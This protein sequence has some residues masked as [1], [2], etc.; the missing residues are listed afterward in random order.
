MCSTKNSA[1]FAIH[2]KPF[3]AKLYVVS[4]TVIS[5]NFFHSSVIQY[6]GSSFWLVFAKLSLLDFLFMISAD[7][8]ECLTVAVPQGMT[9]VNSYGS[10]YILSQSVVNGTGQIYSLNLCWI[11]FGRKLGMSKVVIVWNQ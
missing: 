4:L 6:I 3:F 5:C 9:C 10:Y 8:N 11:R 2:F 7:V 1:Q